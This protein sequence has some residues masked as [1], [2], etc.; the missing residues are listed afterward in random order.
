MM[1]GKTDPIKPY[2]LRQLALC[3]PILITLRRQRR[4]I[5]NRRRRPSRRNPP[6]Q[7]ITHRPQIRRFHNR[8]LIILIAK[9]FQMLQ[10]PPKMPALP[11]NDAQPNILHPLN[12]LQ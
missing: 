6:P 12:P 7:R 2:I 1:F 5:I 8:L 3:N 9:P 11:A 10:P 4:I